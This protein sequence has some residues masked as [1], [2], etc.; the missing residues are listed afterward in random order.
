MMFEDTTLHAAALGVL[1]VIQGVL[2]SGV[3]V[4]IDC[5]DSTGATP[6][7]LAVSNSV[8]APDMVRTLVGAG[9]N[10]HIRDHQG[11]TALMRAVM[12]GHHESVGVLM[13]AGARVREGVWSAFDCL[14]DDD[15]VMAH[16]L[17]LKS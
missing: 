1:P 12:H 11:M 17:L 13:R 8:D 16:F 7:M 14:D 3:R 10:V 4:D 2:R 5:T 9:A 6:L 15:Y